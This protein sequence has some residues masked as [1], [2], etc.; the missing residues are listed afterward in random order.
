[1]A[2]TSQ[3]ASYRTSGPTVSGQVIAG[4]AN[5]ETELALVGTATFTGDG[6][7]TSATLN[8][9]D[10]TNT[11]DFTPTAVLASRSGGTAAETVSAFVNDN[12]NGGLSATVEFSAAPAAAA[13]VQIAFVVLK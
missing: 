8:Y 1:M 6:S 5:S 11:L 2:I 7:S 4:N 12:A 9:I 13:T 10:G 3:N